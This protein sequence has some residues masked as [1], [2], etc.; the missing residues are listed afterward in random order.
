MTRRPRPS[1]N[2]SK[3]NAPQ[4]Q[5]RTNEEPQTIDTALPPPLKVRIAHPTLIFSDCRSPFCGPFNLFLHAHSHF[6]YPQ[7]EGTPECTYV[8]VLRLYHYW[9]HLSEDSKQGF[10]T[11]FT[12]QYPPAFPT[13][14]HQNYLEI[15][16]ELTAF[17][18]NGFLLWLKDRVTAE[19][20]ISD[21]E[22]PSEQSQPALSAAESSLNE[23]P[24]LQQAIYNRGHIYKKAPAEEI[25][26]IMEYAQRWEALSATEQGKW[27]GVARLMAGT[28]LGLELWNDEV[29]PAP[30]RKKYAEGRADYLKT[31]NESELSEELSGSKD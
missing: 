17:N 11:A 9:R 30:I 3:N 18:P 6:F 14:F 8:T 12:D 20:C 29:V 27:R 10:I 1:K 16:R 19:E 13:G 2:P 24:C 28:T 21:G 15:G 23:T 26:K 4:R 5:S 25:S 31:S 7:D 22:R